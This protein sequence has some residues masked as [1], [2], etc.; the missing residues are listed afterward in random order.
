MQLMAE[1]SAAVAVAAEQLQADRTLV[2]WE[3]AEPLA[4]EPGSSACDVLDVEVG[5]GWMESVLNTGRRN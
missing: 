1:L 2:C 5:L 4:A 3:K